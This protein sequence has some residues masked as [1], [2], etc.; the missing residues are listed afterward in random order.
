MK[1]I[2]LGIVSAFLVLSLN[3]LSACTTTSTTEAPAASPAASVAAAPTE[4]GTS[5]GGNH[6]KKI[7]INNAILSELDKI[8]GKLGVPALS[9]KIQASRP[10][11]KTEDLVSKKVI[12]QA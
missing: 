3:W 11:T 10:Y 1:N 5:H 6:G 12:D 7:N 8:E 2:A 4:S 9:N